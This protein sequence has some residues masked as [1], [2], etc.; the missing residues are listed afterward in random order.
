MMFSRAAVVGGSVVGYLS[1]DD[2]DNVVL[3]VDND[4]LT[5]VI[6]RLR[7]ADRKVQS[8]FDQIKQEG[9]TP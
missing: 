1:I 2:D 8:V 9:W 7:E 5:E 4:R 3:E 6:I